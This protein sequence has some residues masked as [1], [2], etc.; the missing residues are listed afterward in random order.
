MCCTPCSTAGRP[1]KA[2]KAAK[3]AASPNSFLHGVEN[4][5]D[6]VLTPKAAGNP[7]V[8]VLKAQGLYK[9]PLGSGKHD[10]TCPWVAEH[11]DGLDTDLLPSEW[12]IDYFSVDPKGGR[13]VGIMH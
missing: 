10:M 3:A 5:A 11:T 2:A 12:S 1:K 8:A 7:V 9:S 6:D 4:D 13:S